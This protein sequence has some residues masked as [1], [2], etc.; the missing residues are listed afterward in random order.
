MYCQLPVGRGRWRDGSG[1]AEL[2][3]TCSLEMSLGWSLAK[4]CG[5]RSQLWWLG[6]CLS[7]R[8]PRII[9]RIWFP[10]IGFKGLCP[11]GNRSVCAFGHSVTW[12][13]TFDVTMWCNIVWC[14]AGIENQVHEVMKMW[15]FNDIIVK[16][17]LITSVYIECYRTMVHD[18][19]VMVHDGCC[20]SW[21]RV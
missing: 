21:L 11:S 5:V 6:C 7:Y 17:R 16:G 13:R 4:Y 10:T 8:K 14:P 12:A 19:N 3:K 1:S 20:Y 18:D 15:T 9:V 2:Q